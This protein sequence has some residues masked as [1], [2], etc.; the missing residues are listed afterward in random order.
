MDRLKHKDVQFCSPCVALRTDLDLSCLLSLHLMQSSRNPLG[1]LLWLTPW[2]YEF[3]WTWWTSS[4]I[5][6]LSFTESCVWQVPLLFSQMRN[7]S[8]FFRGSLYLRFFLCCSAGAW[9]QDLTHAK[10]ILNNTTTFP[11]FKC[12]S[13]FSAYRVSSINMWQHCCIKL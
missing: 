10:H 6:I 7:E 5:L 13:P 9:T 1:E 8:H 12:C 2:E 11:F 4:K 3:C